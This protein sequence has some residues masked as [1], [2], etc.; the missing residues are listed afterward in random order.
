MSETVTLARDVEATAIPAGNK[1]FVPEGT[2]VTITQTLGGSFT[3]T[4]DYGFLVR[5]EARDADALGKEVPA[6][7]PQASTAGMPSTPADLRL[8]VEDQLRTVYD[9]EI[10]VNIVDLG[11]IYRLDVVGGDAGPW[12][13]EI[14][15]SMTAPGCGMGDVLKADAENKV[16]ELTGV[17]EARVEIVWD[18]PWDQSRMSD[19]ARLQ[20]GMD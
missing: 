4:T 10:P 18:P 14:D 13:V 19:A 2:P 20:L 5:I 16:R 15:M 11:L 8:R 9:P 17:R 7:A 3:V 1:V 12:D 6:D